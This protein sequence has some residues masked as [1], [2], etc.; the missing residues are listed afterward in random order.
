MT[1]FTDLSALDRLDRGLAAL[2]AHRQFI[3]AAL[4]RRGAQSKQP[5]GPAGQA[6]TPGK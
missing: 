6:E 3:V 1:D 2:R 5:P 4:A